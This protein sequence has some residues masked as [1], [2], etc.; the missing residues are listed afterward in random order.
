[1]CAID[2]VTIT[3]HVLV[4]HIVIFCALRYMESYSLVHRCECIIHSNTANFI[5]WHPF[6]IDQ[7]SE[8][9]LLLRS[10]YQEANSHSAPIS[11]PLEHI[12]QG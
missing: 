9:S 12:S 2:Q 3:A 4:S 10:E 1:V 5:R 11:Y 8:S 7:V 6:N